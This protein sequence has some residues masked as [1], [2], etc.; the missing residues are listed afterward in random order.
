MML[1]FWSDT[2]FLTTG[3]TSS[4]SDKNHDSMEAP[5]IHITHD[6]CFL[7]DVLVLSD[8]VG[9][10]VHSSNQVKGLLYMLTPEVF[11]PTWAPGQR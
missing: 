9:A 4:R 10:A 5:S 8:R 1:Y 6:V 7:P 11:A 3:S 2:A